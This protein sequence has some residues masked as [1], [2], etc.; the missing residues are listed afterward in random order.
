VEQQQNS[1]FEYIDRVI[2]I[3]RV[4][5]VVKGGR[6]FRFGAIVVI[7]DGNGTYGVGKGKAGE[8]P[9]AIRKA[10]ESAK[11]Q[12][13]KVPITD[14]RTIPHEVLGHYGAGKV[15]LKPATKG[16]GV[17]AGGPVRAIMEA[18]GYTDVISKCIGSRNSMNIVRAVFD[19]AGKL[20][21]AKTVA[22][23]RGK[24]LKDLWG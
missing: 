22:K 17:I 2:A 24:S 16:T 1:E 20:L 15:L 6:R 12:M 11:K 18:A 14:G 19:G 5:K 23:N 3:N 10:T 21:D 8:V 7:G 4:A 9:E 13:M